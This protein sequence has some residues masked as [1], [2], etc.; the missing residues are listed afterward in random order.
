VILLNIILA[1]Y[2]DLLIPNQIES[3]N[4]KESSAICWNDGGLYVLGDSGQL[5][6]LK[7]GSLVVNSFDFEDSEGLYVDENHIFITEERSRKIVILDKNSLKKI[8][9]KQLFFSGRLNRGFEGITY[10]PISEEFLIITEENPCQIIKT[11]KD[12]NTLGY[13]DLLISE[14]SDLVFFENALWVLSDINA[15]IY[16]LNPFTFNVENS[17]RIKVVNPEGITFSENQMIIVSDNLEKIYYYEI[18][19]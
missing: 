13:Y 5:G 3:S 16:K 8:D 18:P 19:Q 2:V 6:F 14:A 1:F 15:T 11:D 9:E 17:W 12:F 4:I 10:N 7:D